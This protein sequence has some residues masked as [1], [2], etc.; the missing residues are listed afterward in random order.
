MRSPITD[1][2]PL[3]SALLTLCE[4]FQHN[5]GLVT[6]FNAMQNFQIL[7]E[8]YRLAVYRAAQEGLTNI[9]RHADAQNAWIQINADGANLTLIVEDDGKGFEHQ[10]QNNHGAGLLGLR[11]RAEQLGGQ[12]QIRERTGGGTQLSF[13]IPMPERSIN[14]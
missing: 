8:P 14:D 9:Q 6:H 2:Q 1:N 12:I 11:E 3:E 7:P 10:A 4:S 13:M 5:T